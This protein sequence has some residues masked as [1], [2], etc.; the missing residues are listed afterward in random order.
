DCSCISHAQV[1]PMDIEERYEDISHQFLS[2]DG[3]EYTLQGPAGGDDITGLSAEPAHYQL[4]SELGRGFNNLSQVN[5]ARHIPTGQLVAVK[6]TNLDDCTEEELLQLMSQN[7]VLLSRLF[8]HPNLLTSRLVFSSCCQLWV[9]TPLMAYS[10]D[11][12]LRTYFPDGMSESLIA[13]LLYGVLKALEYLHRMGY[14][15]GVK[16][17]HILLSGEGRV[18]LSGL[19]SVYS[20]MREGKRMRTVFD[21]PH[22]SPALLPWLSP[23]LL[24]QDL[25]GYGVKSDIY[26]LGIVACELVSGRV[27]FQDM[28]PTQMLL[29]KLRGSHCC[30]LDVAPFPLGELGGLK[31]SRSGVDS[32]IGESVATGSLTHSTTAPPTDRPQ[33]P[34]PKNHSATLHN[35]V[36]LC[37]QQQPERV[38][39]H[40]SDSFLSLMYPAVPLASPEDPPVS[41]PPTPSCHTPASA[42]ADSTEAVWDF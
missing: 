39:R 25:H 35:L 1:Q 21:M 19:H 30:L 27:P 34:G 7:E 16:A 9:L 29:Q 14:I 20:M 38:K 15:H 42:T 23:E 3:S 37:L 13:Y 41:S 33:S 26:S 2:C 11:T 18:Y 32:G 40:T 8:R 10:A 36:Q 12:L 24:R 22:H 5:M 4:L 28:P 31:V 6:Q 17:S